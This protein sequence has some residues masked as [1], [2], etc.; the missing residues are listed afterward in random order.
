MKQKNLVMVAVAVG[1]GLIAAIAVAKLTAGSGGGPEMGRVLVAK[2]DIPIGTKLTEKDLEKFLAWADIPKNMVP[3]DAV[4]DIELVKGKEATRTLRQ[5]NPI[6]I[7]DVSKVDSIAIPAGHKQITFKVTEVD[8]VKGFARPGSKVDVIYIERGSNNKVRTAVLLRDMLVLAVNKVD[9]ILEGSGRAI[10]QVDSV[11]LAVTDTQATKVAHAENKGT[12]KLVLRNEPLTDSER[13]AA[14]KAEIVFDTDPFDAKEP[15]PAPKT[16]PAVEQ[17]W[18]AVVQ[19]KKAVPLNTLLN[20]DNVAEFFTTL[21]VKVAPEG[22]EKSLD[23]LKGKYVVRAM[24]PGQNLFKVAVANEAVKIETPPEMPMVVET[25]KPV[26]K[27]PRYEQIIQAG[28]KATKVIWMEVA[29]GNWKP[30]DSD[31]EADAYQPPE[32]KKDEK[33]DNAAEDKKPT[34]ETKPSGN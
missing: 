26:K 32:E 1:C 5:G 30:F 31:K 19:A 29:P 28:G 33:K 7:A 25:P 22:A 2:T 4:A 27:Y 15:A 13:E 6:S 3:A 20:A 17:K 10:D 16:T 21:E 11:S 34:D 23:D 14:N 9:R 8:A 18:E 12:L 24:E